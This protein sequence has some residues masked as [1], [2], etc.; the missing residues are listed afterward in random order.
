MIK[1]LIF[2]FG[3]VL[4]NHDLQ[5]LLE[6]HFGDDEVSLIGFTQNSIRSEIYKHVR[7]WN[8]PV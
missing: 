6:R 5:P 4:V 1:N 7:P 8:N 3:K 2:D